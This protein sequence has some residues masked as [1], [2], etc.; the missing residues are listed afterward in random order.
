[1]QVTKWRMV[2]QAHH[3]PSK[4]FKRRDVPGA[5]TPDQSRLSAQEQTSPLRKV[6]LMAGHKR[7]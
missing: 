1:M 4:L 5:D 7:R 3:I 6:L 2:I